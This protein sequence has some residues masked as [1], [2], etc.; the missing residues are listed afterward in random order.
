MKEKDIHK[1]IEQSN[2]K[3]K[4]RLWVKISGDLYNGFGQLKSSNGVINEECK[5]ESEPID[6]NAY[7]AKK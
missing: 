2:L 7:K 1:M 6:S 5:I 4:H 3:D